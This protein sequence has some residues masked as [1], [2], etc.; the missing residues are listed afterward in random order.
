MTFYFVQL[1]PEHATRFEVQHAFVPRADERD[2]NSVS[3]ELTRNINGLNIAGKLLVTLPVVDYFHRSILLNPELPQDDIMHT[4]HWVCPCVC[5][6]MS[7]RNP[8][9]LKNIVLEY[10]P[11]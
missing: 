8:Q 2:A 1:F 9:S 5:F 6:F 7:G 11:Q 3:Q 4:T 10:F